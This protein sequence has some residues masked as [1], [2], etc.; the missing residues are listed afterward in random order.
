MLITTCYNVQL[1]FHITW[2]FPCLGLCEWLILQKTEIVML[3]WGLWWEELGGKKA[4]MLT[5]FCLFWLFLHAFPEVILLLIYLLFC[6]SQH[7]WFQSDVVNLLLLLLLLFLWFVFMHW[8]PKINICDMYTDM[9]VERGVHLEG[10]TE[11]EISKSVEEIV[12]LGAALKGWCYFSWTMYTEISGYQCKILPWHGLFSWF[13]I[14]GLLVLGF[15]CHFMNHIWSFLWLID[16]CFG[17]N[18]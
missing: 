5:S 3:A 6:V 11:E 15:C 18:Q 14:L 10:L 17:V 4:W 16:T 9:G 13:G 2:F 1:E 12:K 7:V 8:A